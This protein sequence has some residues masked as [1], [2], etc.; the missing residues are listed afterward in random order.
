MFFHL[1]QA[2]LKTAFLD[3]R[4]GIEQK[5]MIALAFFECQVVSLTEAKVLLA[6]DQPDLREKSL[7]HLHRTVRTRIV[8]DEDFTIDRFGCFED[9][10]KA[11]LQIGRYI[12]VDDD[13]RE[14]QGQ[15]SSIISTSVAS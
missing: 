14:L 15:E 4:I 1:G 11:L 12:V 9:R 13:N 7:H 6:L 8:H 10:M 5:D 3:D 2:F